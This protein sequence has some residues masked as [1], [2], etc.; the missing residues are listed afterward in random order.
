MTTQR[1]PLPIE[2]PLLDAS[3]LERFVLHHPR[4]RHRFRL[5]VPILRG[6]CHHGPPSARQLLEQH[7][8]FEPAGMLGRKGW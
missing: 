1:A 8:V 2:V 6:H 5:S 7:I 4:A 3:L